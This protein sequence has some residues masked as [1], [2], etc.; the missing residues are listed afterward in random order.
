M[1]KPILALVAISLVM[2]SLPANAQ[3]Y[4]RQLAL[5]GGSVMRNG[6]PPTRLDSFVYEAGGHAWHIYGDEGVYSIPP[7]MEFTKP[8]RI[9]AG[10]HG[11]RKAGLQTGHGSYMPDAW[12]GDEFV[13]GPEWSQS[14][15]TSSNRQYIPPEVL[16]PRLSDIP[17]YSP[18]VRDRGPL[19]IMS[20]LSEKA[21][22]STADKYRDRAVTELDKRQPGFEWP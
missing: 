11:R 5:P 10:I 21:I 3:G 6:L 8:H 19:P 12:G 13:D 20:E 16:N 14:G 4:S 1:R 7:F 22:L 9:E 17:V 2:L 15:G 18:P